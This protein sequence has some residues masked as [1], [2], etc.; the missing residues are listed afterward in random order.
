[1]TRF[2]SSELIRNDV[3]SQVLSRPGLPADCCTIMVEEGAAG[4]FAAGAGFSEPDDMTFARWLKQGN[5]ANFAGCNDSPRFAAEFASK[6][7][8]VVKIVP[9][10][11]R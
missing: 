8:T 1:M 10:A 2:A 6:R 9:N 3:S 4:V 5:C 7:P 11:A